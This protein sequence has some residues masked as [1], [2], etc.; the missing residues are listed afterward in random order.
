[1]GFSC[2]VQHHA[3]FLAENISAG[4]LKLNRALPKKLTYHDPCYLGRYGGIYEEPRRVLGAIDSL[5]I[6]EME[7]SRR[8][9]FCCGAGGGWMWMDEKIGK[10]INIQRLEDA[11]ETK[12]EWISTACPFCVTMFDDAIKSLDREENLKIWD[13][14]EIVDQALGINSTEGTNHKDDPSGE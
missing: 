10:R 2:E 11:L 1:M 13:I 12:P 6:K 7:R 3:E 14:A 9:S 8:K 5:E 4:R